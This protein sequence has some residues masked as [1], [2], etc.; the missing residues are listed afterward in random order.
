M[1]KPTGIVYT[2]NTGYTEKYA[3][4]LGEQ[5]GLPVFSAGQAVILGM[6]KAA[7]RLSAKL[8]YQRCKIIVMLLR[9]PY[10]TGISHR[11]YLRWIVQKAPEQIPYRCC[12]RGCPE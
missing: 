4:L 5:L 6:K 2:S 1:G 12:R 9:P 7:R 11:F 3:K 10:T 8:L